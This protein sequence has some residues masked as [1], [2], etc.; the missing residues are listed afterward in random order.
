MKIVALSGW[1]GS[2]KDMVANYLVEKRG[3][4]RV[5]FADP[6]KDEVARKWNLPRSWMDD[7]AFKEKPLFQYPVSPRDAFSRMLCEYM[8]K[9]FRSSAGDTPAR[10]EYRDGEFYGVFPTGSETEAYR[11]YWTPRAFCILEGSTARTGD[12][13]HWVKKAVEKMIPG[14]GYVISDLRYQSELDAL[15]SA[16]P[17]TVIAVRIE[18]FETTV[19]TDSSERD[20]D[21]YPFPF[22]IDNRERLEVTK[23]SVYSQVDEILDKKGLYEADQDQSQTSQE[24]DSGRATQASA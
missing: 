11:L 19:S 17:N 1:K 5:S 10:F 9:E 14:G 18:R 3:F 21:L 16:V 6:L 7:P 8:V 4:Q 23:D 2:G 24:T 22:V 12:R 20:L 13:N 15:N